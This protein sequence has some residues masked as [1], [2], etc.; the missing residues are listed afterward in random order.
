MNHRVLALALA[1]TMIW[2]IPKPA[3][4]LLLVFD[5][6]A[7]TQL[8]QEAKN[9]AQEIRLLEQ[10]YAEQ[11]KELEELYQFY[12]L[13]A[14]ATSVAQMAA[15][16]NTFYLKSPMLADAI[17]LEQAFRGFGL[18]TSLA[19]KIRG[20]LAQ[21][22]YY[23]ASNADFTGWHL[24]AQATATSGQIASAQ[25]AYTSATTRSISISEMLSAVNNADPKEAA[26]LAARGTLETATTT[27]QTNQLMAANLLQQ[28]QKDAARQQEEQAY[29]YSVD[30][31]R[32]HAQAAIA[33]AQGG[34]VNLVTQ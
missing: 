28:A 14:H 23:H 31:Y 12:E 33:A 1:I 24:N 32:Q 25:D 17:Q 5:G 19:G 20:V 4:A 30:D 11:I 6:A 21:I 9:G 3:H 7:V 16:L 27:A 29:R 13:F 10:Q 2:S 22:Q 26:D 8:V 15:I 18:Q 34:A